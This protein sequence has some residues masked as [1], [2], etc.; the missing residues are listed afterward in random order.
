MI[1]LILGIERID[2]HFIV[3]RIV[4]K[5]V[6][7]GA[8]DGMEGTGINLVK[9]IWWWR[10]KSNWIEWGFGQGSSGMGHANCADGAHLKGVLHQTPEITQKGD[11]KRACPPTVKSLGSI[12]G[13]GAK[14]VPVWFE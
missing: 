12:G 5:R 9:S 7:P 6:V 14:L 2:K 3:E 13:G 8:C 1:N 4:K 11:E 10:Q